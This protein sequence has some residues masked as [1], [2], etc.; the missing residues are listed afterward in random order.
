MEIELLLDFSIGEIRYQM[1]TFAKEHSTRSNGYFRHRHSSFEIHYVSA[2]SCAIRVGSILYEVRAGQLILIP[3]GIYHSIKET[4]PDISKM[5][6]GIEP[7]EPTRAFQEHEAAMIVR[8][9]QESGTA[10]LEAGELASLLEHIRQ[11]ASVQ[12]MPF[13]D[14][15]SMK[16]MLALLVLGLYRR[17]DRHDRVYSPGDALPAQRDQVIDNFF[18][19]NFNLRN[20]DVVLADQLCVSCRQLDR[21]LKG[22]YG[23]SYRD[24]LLEVRLEVSIDLLQTTEKSIAEISELTGY[25][26]PANFSSFVKKATGMTPS[27][28]RRGS[29]K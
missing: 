26:S 3:P 24:K 25:G 2:G 20:G 8:C 17:L 28:I 12:N 4:S 15:E 27:A 23:K 11:A 18:N 19:Q 29:Q 7:L 10:V 16:A 13:S 14:R 6:I 22:L 5:C 1:T 9:F 21:I